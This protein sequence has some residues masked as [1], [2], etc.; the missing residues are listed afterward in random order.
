[1]HTISDHRIPVE[2]ISLDSRW[3]SRPV[4]TDLYFPPAGMADRPSLLLVNDGQDFEKMGFTAILENLYA[5]NELKPL[6][7]A[8]IHCGAERKMEYG[9]P[10]IPDFKGRGGRADHYAGFILDELLPA[11]DRIRPLHTFSEIAFA[12]FSLGGLSALSM[13]W[14]YPDIFLK[15]GVFSGSL[16]WRSVDQ[17]DAEYDDD[18]HR[19]M[20]Q[21][22]RNGRFDPR[23][24]FFFQCGNMDETKDR[25]HN[26][27]IDS[28]DDTLD[29]IRELKAKGYS[30]KQDI[31]YMEMADGRHDVPTWGRAMPDFLTW[32]WGRSSQ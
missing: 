28:I 3:L 31:R 22:I 11:I 19:I 14:N 8:G 24:K 2:E 27:I 5:E 29:L 15:A 1:M 6:L 7:C 30:E 26:G 20:H 13:V 32:G 16:W 4:K 18:K 10:G 25:N 12:G 23:L 17:D 21:V 9:V